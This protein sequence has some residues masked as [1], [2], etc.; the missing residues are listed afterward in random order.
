MACIM[1]KG[2]CCMK[3]P[4][5]VHLPS[6]KRLASVRKE[7]HTRKRDGKDVV[8]LAVSRDR[9]WAILTQKLPLLASYINENLTD[10]SPWSRVTTNGLWE[11]VDRT[12]GRVGGWHKGMWRV[13]S[14]D[15]GAAC[16][17]FEN[18]R[19]AASKAAIVGHPECYECR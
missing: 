1:G 10:G 19:R 7:W 8:Y 5:C 9:E 11:N 18:A 14:L 16:D 15:L 3:K 2:V 13:A 12:G 6:S 17:A 4:E